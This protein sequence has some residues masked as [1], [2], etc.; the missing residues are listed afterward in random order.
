MRR[1]TRLEEGAD[2]GLGGSG[3]G[4][5]KSNAPAVRAVAGDDEG[6]VVD[7]ALGAEALGQAPAPGPLLA[8]RLVAGAGHDVLQPV[9]GLEGLGRDEPGADQDVLVGEGQQGPAELVGR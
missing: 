2:A 1:S 7:A 4:A 8:R 6:P 5:A 9:E 3:F